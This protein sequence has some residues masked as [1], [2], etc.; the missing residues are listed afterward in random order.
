[1]TTTNPYVCESLEYNVASDTGSLSGDFEEH[2]TLEG[3]G[4]APALRITGMPSRGRR[5]AAGAPRTQT[6][7][8]QSTQQAPV[9]HPKKNKKLSPTVLF[10]KYE[11][12]I[13]GALK[14][15]TD[16]CNEL[17]IHA[18]KDSL[19]IHASKLLTEPVNVEH[20]S[21]LTKEYHIRYDHIFDEYLTNKVMAAD[22]YK[23][24]DKNTYFHT[25]LHRI[26]SEY[27]KHTVKS[28]HLED[29]DDVARLAHVTLNNKKRA[30]AC[31]LTTPNMEH[32]LAL[33]TAHET[34]VSNTTDNP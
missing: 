4:G 11:Q 25:D 1:M 5:R 6:P 26:I 18:H 9:H 22:F 29:H 8:A 27:E 14:M 23:Y 3:R 33:K 16:F 31:G 17:S 20:T 12:H 32:R 19:K 30:K 28:K 10:N 15:Y 34:G 2:M 13:L 21:E 7:L 24:E